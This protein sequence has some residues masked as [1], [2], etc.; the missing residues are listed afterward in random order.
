MAQTL[1]HIVYNRALHWSVVNQKVTLVLASPVRRVHRVHQRQDGRRYPDSRPIDHRHQWLGEVY[2][3]CHV[4]EK[5][6]AGLVG[7]LGPAG[8]VGGDGREHGEV[9]AAGEV[10]GTAADKLTPGTEIV[11]NNYGFV[12]VV[13]PAGA[14]DGGDNGLAVLSRLPEQQR[15]R[16][17]DVSVEGIVLVR[18]VDSDDS[19]TIRH[20]DRQAG[21]LLG[22]LP[23]EEVGRGTGEAEKWHL[24]T[25]LLWW[26]WG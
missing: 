23:V 24:G 8:R 5:N 4:V 16:G 3:G 7:E 11:N 22:Q 2:E 9:V 18:P 14:G 15:E 21:G 12:V 26:S 6:L 25:G 13:V 17:V 1:G 10:P 20:T 19:D